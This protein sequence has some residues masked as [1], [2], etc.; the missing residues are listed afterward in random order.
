M[1]HMDKWSLQW[2]IAEPTPDDVER[3]RADRW[4]DFDEQQT[5]LMAHLHGKLSGLG[6]HIP[7]A[8]A[9]LTDGMFPPLRQPAMPYDVAHT[10]ATGTEPTACC[11]STATESP[12]ILDFSED[13]ASEVASHPARAEAMANGLQDLPRMPRERRERE[14]S[15]GESEYPASLAGLDE[16]VVEDVVDVLNSTLLPVWQG[17]PGTTALPVWQ[18]SPNGTP[19]VPA[20][21]PPLPPPSL[22][23]GTVGGTPLGGFHGR[24]CASNQSVRPSAEVLHTAASLGAAL[25]NVQGEWIQLLRGTRGDGAPTLP[26]SKHDVIGHASGQYARSPHAWTPP[27]GGLPPAASLASSSRCMVS[28]PSVPAHSKRLW[29]E[30]EEVRMLESSHQSQMP[31]AC[32]PSLHTSPLFSPFGDVHPKQSPV[33]GQQAWP[34]GVSRRDPVNIMQ[35]RM[36]PPVMMK[37]QKDEYGPSATATQS[38]A[39][40]DCSPDA[41]S[42][43]VL[44]SSRSTSAHWQD[45]FHNHLR[46]IVSAAQRWVVRGV[47]AAWVAEVRL[48]EA[49]QQTVAHG[50]LITMAFAHLILLAWKRSTDSAR[51]ETFVSVEARLS[52]VCSVSSRLLSSSTEGL[53]RCSTTCCFTSWRCLCA[54][55]RARRTQSQLDRHR[56]RALGVKTACAEALHRGLLVADLISARVIFRS[57]RED[58]KNIVRA[59]KSP[60][61]AAERVALAC[62]NAAIRLGKVRDQACLSDVVLTWHSVTR[63][64]RTELRLSQP[65]VMQPEKSDEKEQSLETKAEQ[66]LAAT[67]FLQ[68]EAMIQAQEAAMHRATLLNNV[69]HLWMTLDARLVLRDTLRAWA[70]LAAGV[71]VARQAFAAASSARQTQLTRI[72]ASRADAEAAILARTAINAWAVVSAGRNLRSLAVVEQGPSAYVWPTQNRSAS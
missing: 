2:K 33:D 43:S 4:K 70:S 52:S 63:L 64:T 39:S 10:P 20:S 59:V 22:P 55:V 7:E 6:G 8:E 62:R 45:V 21:V 1:G 40:G 48:A 38:T 12:S 66:L 58:T 50:A 72:L 41:A 29:Q 28:A 32:V 36:Q 42:A 30:H 35:M 27:C 14:P 17:A 56:A 34:I 68:H 71:C 25:D 31:K 11:S 54:E 69:E 51:L 53:R 23:P 24:S 65:C 9:H 26:L 3:W 61:A 47:W 13:Q 16:S 46:A 60:A 15:P 67:S 49:A 18:G 37:F 44:P 57:W 5:S 19:S